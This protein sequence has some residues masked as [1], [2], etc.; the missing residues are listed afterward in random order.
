MTETSI[1]PHATVPNV[2]IV[3]FDCEC[4]YLLALPVPRKE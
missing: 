3:Q 2:D 4:G 1:S